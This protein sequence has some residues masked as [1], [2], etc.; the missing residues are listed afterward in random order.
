MVFLI[1]S[2]VC[3]WNG[4]LMPSWPLL[5]I[6]MDVAVLFPQPRYIY[7]P[8]QVVEC[9]LDLQWWNQLRNNPQHKIIWSAIKSHILQNCSVTTQ[10]NTMVILNCVTICF[11]AVYVDSHVL[12]SWLWA[13]YDIDGHYSR[14]TAQILVN[15]CKSSQILKRSAIN[16]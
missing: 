12:T 8:Y 6:S 10:Y 11:I 9:L 7:H 4:E 2:R 1:Y 13:K 3:M 15:P 16:K 5:Q 14:F